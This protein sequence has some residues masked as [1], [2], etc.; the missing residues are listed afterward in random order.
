MSEIIDPTT[1]EITVEAGDQPTT[2]PAV[3]RDAQAIMAML[4]RL[5]GD[6]AFDVLKM[7]RLMDLYARAADRQAAQ[8][9]EIA[10]NRVQSELE[11]VRR[12]GFNPQTKSHYATLDQVVNAVNP[13]ATRH[14]F[15][16]SFGSDR[17]DIPEHYGVTCMVGHTS[18]CTKLYRHDVP[19][20]STG[21]GGSR[22]KTNTH[23]WASAM[24]YGKRYLL[25]GIFNLSTGVEDDD[26]NRA[27]NRPPVGLAGREGDATYTNGSPGQSST[28]RPNELSGEQ[29]KRLV[30]L[31]SGSGKSEAGVIAWYNKD[32]PEPLHIKHLSQIHPDDL[33]K[34]ETLL[35]TAKARLGQPA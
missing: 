31:L 6:P 1:G 8:D 35:Q 34:L 14:G 32:L 13:V 25:T 17:S 23:A 29:I 4:D 16:I 20:D 33:P 3:T 19:A 10:M 30:T 7:E 22:N 15:N 12:A 18:G 21:P 11:P 24:T 9:Y 2:L 26:G 5:M 27:G 28:G